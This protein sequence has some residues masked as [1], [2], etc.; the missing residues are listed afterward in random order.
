MRRTVAILL[1]GTLLA[2]TPISGWAVDKKQKE[3]PPKTAPRPAPAAPA[4]D[5][6]GKE[7]PKA[8]QAERKKYDNFVDANNNGIDDR[9]EK[10]KKKPDK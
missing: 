8:K 4:K 6:A 9:L 2:T 5:S 3:D 7:R 10:D 1:I